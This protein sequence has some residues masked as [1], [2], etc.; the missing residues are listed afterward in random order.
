VK[1]LMLTL[2]LVLLAFAVT[3]V[4][5]PQEAQ[6]LAPLE[7]TTAADFGWRNY[8]WNVLCIWAL[9]MDPGWNEDGGSWEWTAVDPNLYEDAD[10]LRERSLEAGENAT[11]VMNDGEATTVTWYPLRS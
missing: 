9:Q 7:C 2:A 8:G 4:V 6:A 3:D 10:Q 1:K 5:A 11:Y